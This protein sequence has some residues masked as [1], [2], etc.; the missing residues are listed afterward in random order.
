MSI[1]SAAPTA[2][3]SP[4]S[5]ARSWA[6]LITLTR[7]EL[8]NSQDLSPLGLLKWILEPIAALVVYVILIA[9][10]FGHAE[11]AYPLFILIALIPFRYF[12]GAINS[13][14][15]VL[16]SYGRVI[17]SYPVPRAVL[18]LVPVLAEGASFLVGLTLIVPFAAYYRTGFTV[19]LLWVPVIIV[20]LMILTAGP[21]YIAAVYGLYFPDFRGVAQSLLRLTFL[22]STGLIA[23]RRIPGDGL[24]RYF[25]AN[26]LS[27]IFDSL[28]AIIIRG[29]SP[30]G[31]LILYPLAV[32]L[33]LLV[34]GVVLYRW[35]ERD[36]PKEV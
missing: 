28:R 21:T 8:R 35:R 9:G 3:Q 4:S 18:P 29:R 17:G 11:R 23:L 31:V 6:V 12:S 10:V 30:S 2:S 1:T 13:G 15:N 5:L 20:V 34:I 19:A 26:P 7:A 24:P 25:K 32:G 16:Q 36:F 22:A 14:M 27:G 33:V